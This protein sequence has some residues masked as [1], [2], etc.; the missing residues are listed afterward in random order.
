MIKIKHTI[1]VLN[2]SNNPIGDEGIAVIARA[3]DNA[4]I[5]ELYVSSCNIALGGGKELAAGLLSNHSIKL[6]DMRDNHI[7]VH[8]DGDIAVLEAAVAN[9]VCQEVIIDSKYKHNPKIKQ[10]M[11]ILE[12]RKRQEIIAS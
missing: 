9:G 8:V 1:K 11:T 7:T 6:L 4:R 2:I 10:M 3:L 12:R 5:C